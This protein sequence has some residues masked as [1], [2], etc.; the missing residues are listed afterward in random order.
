L[1][2]GHI[3]SCDFVSV[4]HILPSCFAGES[5]SFAGSETMWKMLFF[6]SKRFKF[7]FRFASFRFE[8]KR[9]VHTITL[10]SIPGI[11]LWIRCYQIPGFCRSSLNFFTRF[12]HS[13]K[14]TFAFLSMISKYSLSRKRCTQK[15]AWL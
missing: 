3:L 10:L 12:W 13:M 7:H 2:H 8:A 11:D 15:Q 6:A 9:S 5:W 1:L 4:F 14:T